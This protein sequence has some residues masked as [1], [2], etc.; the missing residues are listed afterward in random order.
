MV[1]AD[2]GSYNQVRNSSEIKHMS[3]GMILKFSP[4]DVYGR[5]F[6]RQVE[7][8]CNDYSGTL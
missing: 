5:S 1:M 2:A 8:L 7:M 3:V 6:S 4:F